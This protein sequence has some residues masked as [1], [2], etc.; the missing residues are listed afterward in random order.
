MRRSTSALIVCALA[1]CSG[2]GGGSAS[3]ATNSLLPEHANSVPASDGSAA[4]PTA[5]R[6]QFD[7]YDR[8]VVS[9][10]VAQGFDEASAI[11][12]ALTTVDVRASGSGHAQITEW[13]PTGNNAVIDV[14]VT[15]TESG[16]PSA[17]MKMTS[18]DT[19]GDFA[20]TLEY[21]VSNDAIP[22][23]VQAAHFGASRPVRSDSSGVQVVVKAL[24]KKLATDGVSEFLKY[25]DSKDVPSDG[26]F[27]GALKLMKALV[28]AIATSV[29]FKALMSQIDELEDCAK[30]PTNE[31]TKKAYK[32]NPA[33]L[34][35]LLEQIEST[36][37][38]IRENTAVA[39]FAQM[40]STG[41]GITALKAVP[42]VGYVVSA[43]TAWSKDTLDKVNQGLVE[44]LKKSI[45]PCA[46]DYRFDGTVLGSHWTATKC[47]GIAGQWDVTITSGDYEPTVGSFRL[48]TEPPAG[49]SVHARMD[50]VTYQLKGEVKITFGQSYEAYFYMDGGSASGGVAGSPAV[51]FREWVGGPETVLPVEVG[52]FCK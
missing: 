14:T 45:V 21:F 46:K 19:N 33:E 31:L 29:N 36:R 17:P 9:G 34:D 18:D 23:D 44:D 32:E 47:A 41:S 1:A 39:F 16:D 13:F 50:I 48:D 24:I 42:W 49:T 11:F 10:L 37:S 27:A 12:V 38:E 8:E 26:E 43:G 25:L 7:S 51:G 35:R 22:A 30:N 28:T 4:S 2:G 40:L 15:P 52:S 5:P 6:V 20:F 3:H